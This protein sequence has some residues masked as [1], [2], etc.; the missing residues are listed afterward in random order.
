[1]VKAM[2]GSEAANTIK[3]A[4]KEQTG[5]EFDDTTL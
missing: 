1:L 3:P 4:S 2:P 5:Q